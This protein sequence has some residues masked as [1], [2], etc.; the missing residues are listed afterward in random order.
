MWPH[1]LPH[2][3]LHAQ[4]S[5]SSLNR[6]LA[7]RSQPVSYRFFADHAAE[8]ASTSSRSSSVCSDRDRPSPESSEPIDSLTGGVRRKKTETFDYFC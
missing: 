3:P 2:V 5:L 1:V 8:G 7:G 4:T 6:T